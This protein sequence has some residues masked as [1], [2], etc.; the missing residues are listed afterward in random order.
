MSR[1]STKGGSKER[2]RAPLDADDVAA[3]SVTAED[4][5]VAQR[6]GKH[7]HKVLDGVDANEQLLPESLC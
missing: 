7:I 4:T 5:H 3:V 6:L 2:L 1:V